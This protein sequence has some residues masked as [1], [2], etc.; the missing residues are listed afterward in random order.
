MVA[1]ERYSAGFGLEDSHMVGLPKVLKDNDRNLLGSWPYTQKLGV[2][3]WSLCF[4]MKQEWRTKLE[5]LRKSCELEHQ[6][7]WLRLEICSSQN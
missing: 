4:G 6:Q 5:K 2:K 7:K 1:L 3:R